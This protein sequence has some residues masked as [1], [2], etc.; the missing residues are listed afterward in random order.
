[1]DWLGHVATPR[2]GD[3]HLVHCCN[4]GRHSECWARWSPHP[5]SHRSGGAVLLGSGSACYRP[6]SI[7]LSG[8]LVGLIASVELGVVFGPNELATEEDQGGVIEH[9][10][11]PAGIVGENHEVSRCP[12]FDSG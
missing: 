1:V 12:D 2:P 5:R 9:S 6:R 4:L 10:Q 8:C 3:C 11:V 7:V